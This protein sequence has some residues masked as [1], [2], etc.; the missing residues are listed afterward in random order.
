MSGLR[1]RDAG[2]DCHLP[3]HRLC[4]ALDPPQVVPCAFLLARVPG[5]LLRAAT[6]ARAGGAQRNEGERPGLGP[7]A[8]VFRGRP[9][10][11]VPLRRAKT[12]CSTWAMSQ[13]ATGDHPSRHAV[14][15]RSVTEL[16]HPERNL[17]GKR[18]L[19]RTATEERNGGDQ[20]DLHRH[21][22]W[23]GHVLG[24]RQM[25]RAGSWPSSWVARYS[26]RYSPMNQVRSSA[27]R[28]STQERPEL[29]FRSRLP[30]RP[31]RSR[32]P[33][34]RPS[35]PPAAGVGDVGGERVHLGG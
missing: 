18:S 21:A 25:C 10:V 9:L 15:Y 6:G 11:T 4:L 2:S 13:G 32:S 30:L 19:W 26:A 5:R 27:E 33:C 31:R 24:H 34:P 29:S 17:R 35:K 3:V 12:S 8:S 28:A 1:S 7:G 22:P 14:C 16:K 23:Q 20:R